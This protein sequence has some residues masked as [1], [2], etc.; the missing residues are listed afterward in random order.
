MPKKLLVGLNINDHEYIRFFHSLNPV[1]EKAKQ[2]MS[3]HYI[4]HSFTFL[5]AP[6]TCYGVEDIAI[7]LS[8]CGC[9]C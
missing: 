7:T 9:V 4:Y 8:R 2:Q 1:N 3:L 6:T 5:S